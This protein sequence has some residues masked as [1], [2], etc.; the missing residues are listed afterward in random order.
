M[1]MDIYIKYH[2][3][4]IV[5]PIGAT[6]N[7]LPAARPTPG[8]PG[9]NLSPSSGGGGPSMVILTTES[10]LKTINPKVRFSSFSSV[11]P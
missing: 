6:G 10:P 9:A 3:S 11:I 2:Y 7:P 1:S 5:P 4:L 8:P